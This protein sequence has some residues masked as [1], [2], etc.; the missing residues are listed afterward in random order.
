MDYLLIFI[1]T[2]LINNFV[3]TKF[4]GLC[5]FMSVSTSVETALGMGMATTFVLTLSAVV[6][7]LLNT[8]LL[9]PLNLEFL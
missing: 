5:P 7:Y 8:W 4:L 2:V 1:S 9:I 3:L 6:S